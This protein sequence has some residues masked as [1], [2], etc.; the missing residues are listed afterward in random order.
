VPNITAAFPS[1]SAG[2]SDGEAIIFGPGVKGV[3]TPVARVGI[4]EWPN[5]KAR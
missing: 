1:T 4:N 3:A 2:F 5:L